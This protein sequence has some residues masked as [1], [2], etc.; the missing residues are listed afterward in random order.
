MKII[1]ILTKRKAIKRAK[2]IK[3]IKLDKEKINLEKERQTHFA[4]LPEKSFIKK[5]NQ[6]ADLN[7]EIGVVRFK[8]NK[9][10]HNISSFR[11]QTSGEID[12]NSLIDF[13]SKRKLNLKNATFIH[14]HPSSK[15]YI[16]A[17]HPGASHGDIITAMNLF[18]KT[19]LHKFE[20]SYMDNNNINEVGRM[21]L[22]IDPIKQIE[23]KDQ[24]KLLREQ[25][26][27][28]LL[29][30]FSG[31]QYENHNIM[32][33]SYQKYITYLQN[34]YFTIKFVG[35]NGYKYDSTTNKFIKKE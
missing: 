34:K 22:L 33:K 18:T 9:S 13:A 35:M 32:L 30:A 3:Q 1:N 15:G 28:G 26:K 24:L 21:H 17:E 6:Y 23:V 27:L 29:D 19:G 25:L 31:L 2:N 10:L 5:L 4:A 12:I 14:Q 11:T 8:E 7:N 16:P 20:I